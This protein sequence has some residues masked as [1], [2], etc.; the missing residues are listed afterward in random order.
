M[1]SI[2]TPVST[3]GFRWPSLHMR[4][5]S[6]ILV[7]YFPSQMATFWST[8][9]EVS[10]PFPCGNS[11]CL[12][13]VGLISFRGFIETVR[14]FSSALKRLFFLLRLFCLHLETIESLFTEEKLPAYKL[15][16]CC[17]SVGSHKYH[18][19]KFNLYWGIPP[20]LGWSFIRHNACRPSWYFDVYNFRYLAMTLQDFKVILFPQFIHLRIWARCTQYGAPFK[21]RKPVMLWSHVFLEENFFLL[22]VRTWKRG[23]KENTETNI[24][25]P[26]LVYWKRTYSFFKPLECANLY[27][28]VSF[29][30]KRYS[31]F[32]CLIIIINLLK[33]ERRNKNETYL[34]CFSFSLFFIS[35]FSKTNHKMMVMVWDLGVGIEI[36]FSVKP[37]LLSTW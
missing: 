31:T 25:Y 14:L 21:S 3:R 6:S 20:F 11:A 36:T 12:F 28:S 7:R 26:Q 34:F 1:T 17:C 10:P 23:R 9:P 24:R 4:R 35:L 16:Y 5:H 27:R 2:P 13:Y 18:L 30:A 29:I 33:N 8:R 22:R 32:H 15:Y 19:C 37:S